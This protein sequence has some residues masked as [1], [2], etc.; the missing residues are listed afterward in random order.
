VATGPEHYRKAE[1]LA[2]T[3][4]DWDVTDPAQQAIVALCLAEAQVHATLAVAAAV[5]MRSGRAD[6]HGMVAADD[7][8]WRQ[9]CSRDYAS[10]GE[11]LMATAEQIADLARAIERQAAAIAD[12]TVV[13][14]LYAATR[15]LA[16]NVATLAEWVPD[17]RS[18]G[19]S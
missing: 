16:A 13:G 11:S 1:Q 19:E 4:D 2:T 10:G 12:G 15:R 6:D 18:G 3:P 8:E 7:N 5:A 9:A 14:P 17:D